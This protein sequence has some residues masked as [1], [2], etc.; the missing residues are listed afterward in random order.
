MANNAKY[1]R[2]F[3]MMELSIEDMKKGQL[4]QFAGMVC[5]H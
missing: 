3:M 5:M 1:N 2:R 4:N